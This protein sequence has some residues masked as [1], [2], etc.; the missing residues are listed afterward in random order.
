MS[1]FENFFHSQYQFLT[2]TFGSIAFIIFYAFWVM[3][4]LP[5]SWISMLGGF[6]YGSILGSI[7]VFI[8]ASIGAILTFLTG[9]FFLRNIILRNLSSF[10]R[11]KLIEQS[12]SKEGIK[13][14]ILTR[15]SPAF[16][17][18]LLNLAYSISNV[19]MR[20]FVISLLAIL[21]GTLLYCSL[22]SFAGEITKFNDILEN[23]N[24]L[25]SFILSI[26]GLLSTILVAIILINSIRKSIEGSD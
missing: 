24:D 1:F 6:I 15:L 12:I 3:A 8:G 25:F 7:F 11:L 18:G 9:R 2:S 10:P 16:P 4:L 20:D 19:K 22:G 26:I 14:I 21:P 5:S 23:S 13:L 17:F